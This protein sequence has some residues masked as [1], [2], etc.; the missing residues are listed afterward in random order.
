MS[1]HN[2][3]DKFS[4]NARKIL[5]S[6]QK[7]AQSM[8]S[9]LGSEHILLALAITPKTLAQS[10]LREQMVGL[11]QIRLIVSLHHFTHE[12]N[13]GMTAEAKEALKI[14]AQTALEF[15]HH[16]IDSEH[17]L[18]GIVSQ[19]AFHAAEI[20]DRIGTDPEEIINQIRNFFE[21]MD[22]QA[23]DT[24]EEGSEG[25]FEL[26]PQDQPMPGFSMFGP[27]PPKIEIENFT[28]DLT[29][30]ARLGKIDP[31]IGRDKEIQRVIQILA[32]RT[33]NNP[34][35][36]GDPGVGK[37]AIVEGLAR[38][39]IEQKVPDLFLNKRVVLLD[40]ALL[41]AGT[42]YRGQFEERIKKV[43]EELMR[44]PNTIL[45]IDEIHTIVGAGS[46][47]GG[48]DV[49]NIL[50]PALAKGKLNLIGATTFNEYRKFIE[51]D[52]ALER[53]LQK[54]NVPEPTPEET[55][56][57][58]EGIKPSFE[59]HH[60]VKIT[61]EAIRTAVDLSCRYI[62][63]RHL[64]DKAIDLI[65]EAA[66]AWQLKQVSE[67]S[68]I[69][70]TKAQLVQIRSQKE[71]EVETEN[72][73]KAAELRS[74]ELRLME[75]LKNL[76][77]LPKTISGE[78]GSEDVARIV[79]LWTNIPVETL[80]I[81]E[82]VKFAKI[83]QR[84]KKKII[85]QDEAIE[86]VANAIKRTKSGLA[87]PN[88]PIGSFIFLGPT[89]VGK[90]ELARVLA[91]ELFGSRQA[92]IKIDMSEFMEHHNVSRL[93][94]APPGYVGYEEAGK[95][96]EQI[97]QNPYSIVLFDEIEKADRQVFNLLLQIL[98]D[99]ELTDGQG[100]KVNFRQTIVILT[101]NLGLQELSQRAAIGFTTNRKTAAED[102]EKMENDILK[103]LK[104]EFRP[105]L[106]NR[107]DKIIVFKPLGKP[108]IHKIA[109]L[110]L[111][112]LT[113]RL[114]KQGYRFQIGLKV[115]EFLAQHGW[116]PT[117]GARPLR[118]AI[119][120]LIENPLSEAILNNQFAPGDLIKI[121]LKQN[122]IV[123]TSSTS[124]RKI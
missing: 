107:L 5:I 69:S 49:A 36:V 84:L 14:A 96:T 23:P 44:Q 18:W 19:D 1:D 21:E 99:G 64:P 3:F 82:K 75:R 119:T 11:D 8:N 102:F 110:Q 112:Q 108:E 80:K 9:A 118:R 16:Q 2:I 15:K 66:S 46:A 100:R 33:K 51:K 50:K 71:K 17:L 30:L 95:L 20:V 124:K 121:D 28:T 103:K 22:D 58:L 38:R 57:I 26:P 83:A 117:F 77:N 67:E 65:D 91:E 48:L 59:A 88:R 4:P 92:L 85:G 27:Q 81:Q 105:E 42:M 111:V 106:L 73:P 63:D 114:V 74:L 109:E 93:V 52:A 68:E 104:E 40:L 123:F 54:V 122:H 76:D 39:I 98:E 34:V 60:G 56:A 87:D 94:G 37:T 29:E 120:D 97:R 43:L 24:H 53:R 10:I 79:A 45:F 55:M 89:G 62:N 116:E 72:F 113:D 47:E 25:Q 6:A 41:V 32:R 35:L 31:V 7:I 78:I 12:P 86:S 115:A 13:P 101:S 70:K 61:N 90:T